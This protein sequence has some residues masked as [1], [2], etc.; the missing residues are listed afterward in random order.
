MPV[1]IHPQAVV[2]EDVKIGLGTVVMA[3]AVI[4][5]GTQPANKKSRL[6]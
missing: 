4:N 6:K 1:L 5:S 3:G 2:A